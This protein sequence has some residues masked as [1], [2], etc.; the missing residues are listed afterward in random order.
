MKK[1]LHIIE[2][3]GVGGAEQLVVGIINGLDGY[4][5][6][7]IILNEPDHLRAHI[8]KEHFYLNLRIETKWDLVMAVKKVKR[9]IREH[10]IEIVH[11][12]LYR[13]NILSRL[14]VPDGIPVFNSI[15]AISSLAAY[16]G[17]KLTLHLEKLTYR[18]RQHIVAV[19]REVLNDFIKYV[20][21]RGKASVLY[22]FVDERFF[23]SEPKKDF[24]TG[25]L[26]LVAVG[27]L[28]H[29]KN[30]PY[31]LRAFKEIPSSVTLDI[32]GEGFMRAELQ[33]YIDEQGLP[34]RLCGLTDN[35]PELLPQYDAFVMSSFFEGQPLSLLEAMASGLP[36]ILADI[37]VLREVTGINA[38]YF[39]INDTNS[40][41]NA[42]QSVLNGAVNLRTLS[43]A[44][45]Q[46][47]NAFAHRHQYFERL[48][49]LYEK[50]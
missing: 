29:Q 43:E 1:L 32:Y 5:H 12:H 38:I 44:S 22:N 45:H 18:K 34:V 8:S 13:A 16:N 42:I 50:N 36:A 11:S 49:E 19:S 27:N 40:F 21:L 3:L 2:S 9:Y 46:K 14:A 10:K 4:E 23:A 17:N 39:N 6:H 47:V 41:S 25:G 37:P 30:Y 48:N 15:H 7:L 28:R 31:L 24:S 33:K 26:R 35:L 20:G